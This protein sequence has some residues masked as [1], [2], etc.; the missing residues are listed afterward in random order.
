MRTLNSRWRMLSRAI[1]RFARFKHP[2]RKIAPAIAISRIRGRELSCGKRPSPR[3][4]EINCTCARSIAA[5][6][7]GLVVASAIIVKSGCKARVHC[8]AAVA[9]CASGT[10]AIVHSQKIPGWL[11]HD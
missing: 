4:A 6:A 7:C 9:R 1:C 3:A 10:R 8:A 5:F 11:T 2:T